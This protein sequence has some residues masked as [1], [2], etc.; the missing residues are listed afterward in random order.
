MGYW[1][2][3]IPVAH[4]IVRVIETLG[5]V[6][7]PRSRF[8]SGVSLAGGEP[9]PDLNAGVYTAGAPLWE[10]HTGAQERRR[11]PHRVCGSQKCR[12]SWD[13]AVSFIQNQLLGGGGPRIFT[14]M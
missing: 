11:I 14:R 8:G 7:D 10:P 3:G 1:C 4:N 9:H 13:L 2:I 6:Y 5:P 12:S